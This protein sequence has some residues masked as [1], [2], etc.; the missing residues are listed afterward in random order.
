MGTFLILF[1]E[2]LKKA[3][4]KMCRKF[5]ILTTMV[6]YWNHS[7]NLVASAIEAEAIFH[8]KSHFSQLHNFVTNAYFSIRQT[9]LRL[10]RWDFEECKVSEPLSRDETC[11]LLDKIGTF[12]V[13]ACRIVYS[14]TS[15]SL[16]VVN[17]GDDLFR[18]RTIILLINATSKIVDSREG[19][20][21]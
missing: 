13:W 4:K 2:T 6:S 3:I 16:S 21:L 20:S 15:L 12:T 14:A 11:K 9:A 7:P 19:S 10:K 17:W 5:N 18:D 1:E 8:S